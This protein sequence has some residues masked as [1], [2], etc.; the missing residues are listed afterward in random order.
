MATASSP[1]TGTLDQ[2][3]SPYN[4]CFKYSAPGSYVSK[5][6]SGEVPGPS[7]APRERRAA[8]RSKDLEIFA[9]LPVGHFGLEALDLGILDVNVIID[10]PGAERIAK[11]VILLQRRH[12]LGKRLWQ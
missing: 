7:S 2:R 4:R 5:P 8:G 11:E 6:G 9:M 1:R 12:R 10:K 3:G